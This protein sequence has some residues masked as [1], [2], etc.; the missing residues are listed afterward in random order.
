MG[1]GSVRRGQVKQAFD[2][3]LASPRAELDESERQ[4]GT[5]GQ[6]A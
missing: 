2:R 3:F 1:T 6:Q 5:A 4:L